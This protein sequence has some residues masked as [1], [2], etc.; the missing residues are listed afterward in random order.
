MLYKFLF[1]I[2]LLTAGF[3]EEVS[4]SIRIDCAMKMHNG[5]C[6]QAAGHSTMAFY[7]FNEGYQSALKAGVSHQK[8][9]AI[10][11]L[12][13]WYRKYGHYLGLFKTDGKEVI[14]DAY[15]GPH[16]KSSRRMWK[17]E[18]E[19]LREELEIAEISRDMVF[20][21]GE[22]IGGL[23]GVIL[24]PELISKGAS[25]GLAVAGGYRVWE[26]FIHNV[27]QNLVFGCAGIATFPSALR[28]PYY[29]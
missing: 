26:G 4:E 17:S 9:R 13:M 22:I 2:G 27:T 29:K 25:C 11:N 20:G 19:R 6:L 28:A 1:F 24:A 18:T 7:T 16:T 3:A 14:T 21:V 15:R 10:G 8:L 5:F 23:F 12:F